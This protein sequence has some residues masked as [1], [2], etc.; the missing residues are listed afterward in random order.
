M[1]DS[2]LAETAREW[3][4][5]DQRIKKLEARR[6]KRKKIVLAELDR[7]E[8]IALESSGVK[9]TKV[10][11]FM[12]IPLI[13]EYEKRLTPKQMK[14]ATDRI[15]SVEKVAGLVMAGEIEPEVVDQCTERKPKAA[16]ITVTITEE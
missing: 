11:Q 4:E 13:E 7:R 5:L 15:I 1:K 6:D 16:Y 10:Q 14:K 12:N 2:K 9:V 8:T 3:K